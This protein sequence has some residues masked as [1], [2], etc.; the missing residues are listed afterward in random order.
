[1]AV[2]RGQDDA[3]LLQ[4]WEDDRGLYV[5]TIKEIPAGGGKPAIRN[6]N[7]SENLAPNVL[8]LY[9]K[10]TIVADQQEEFFAEMCKLFD[11]DPPVKEKTSI[12]L[13]VKNWFRGLL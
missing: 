3:I 7:I 1:M 9:G 12:F 10:A 6:L 11:V 2:H 13:K 5:F 4:R 8:E